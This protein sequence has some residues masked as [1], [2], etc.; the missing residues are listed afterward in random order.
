MRR[1]EITQQIEAWAKNYADEMEDTSANSP[2]KTGTDPVSKLQELEASLRDH[3]TEILIAFKQK[4]KKGKTKSVN[5]HYWA[6]RKPEFAEYV[7]LIWTVYPGLN[8]IKP[9]SY[10]GLTQRFDRLV[11]HKDIEKVRVKIK[12]KKKVKS[13]ADLVVEAMNYNKVQSEIFSPYVRKLGFRTCVYCNAQFATTATVSKLVRD[14]KGRLKNINHVPGTFYELDHN[15]PKSIFPFLCTNFYNLQPCCSS[16][17]RRKSNSKFSFSVYYENG[18]GTEIH[19]LHFAIKPK[20]LIEYRVNNKCDGIGAHLCNNGSD[21]PP[22]DRVRTLAR[23]FENTLGVQGVYD[24]YQDF[25]TELLWRHKIYSKG[26]VKSLDTQMKSLGISS[27][28][29]KQFILGTYTEEQDAF[30]RP[31]TIMLQDIWEQLEGQKAT[32]IRP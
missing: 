8:R 5:H 32:K 21:L 11:P 9:Y 13:F 4:T 14:N 28:D 1:I 27:F 10:D 20:D 12:G 6:D 22:T 29:F 2:F 3:S 16:C 19:P 23:N 31:F 25:V 30:K 24:E 17:N 26:F 15:R 18:D 7:K